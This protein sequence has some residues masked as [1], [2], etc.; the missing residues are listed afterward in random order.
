MN[1]SDRPEAVARHAVLSLGSNM[2]DSQALL[3]SAV[4]E[5]AGTP[6]IDR[7]RVSSLYRT[8][9]VGVLD[10]ADFL[11]IVLTAETTLTPSALL[12]RAN[13]IEDAHGRWRDPAYPHGPRT[14]DIDLIIL[15]EC[16]SDTRRLQLPHPRAA[17]R[18]FVLVPWVELEPAAALPQGRIAELLR[19]LDT[20]GVELVAPW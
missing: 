18:A 17:E 11:N 1:G 3:R 7:V 15:G 9:P 20:S 16:T 13:V 2:G 12:T 8:R 6:G 5:L 4:R 19:G 14:L 10:Q